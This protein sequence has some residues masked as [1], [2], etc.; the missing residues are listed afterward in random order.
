[1]SAEV[2]NQTGVN[3][4]CQRAQAHLLKLMYKRAQDNLYINHEEGRTRQF[5]A[6]V[7]KVP[8]LNNE[9]Y[10][11]SIVHRGSTVWNSLPSEEQNIPTFDS[12]KLLLKKKLKE[13]II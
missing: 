3:K 11:K 13:N 5:D 1:M 2:Y 4:L 7:L 10:K 12:F 9:T 6:P 8:F